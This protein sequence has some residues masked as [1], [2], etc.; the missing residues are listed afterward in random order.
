MLAEAILMH[1]FLT[2]RAHVPLDRLVDA[3]LADCA[4][5]VLLNVQ[6][7][8]LQLL[9]R[10]DQLQQFLFLIRFCFFDSLQKNDRLHLT[11]VLVDMAR[12][13][14]RWC[15]QFFFSSTGAAFSS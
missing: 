8:V 6:D 13:R 5:R 9:A 15:E 11:K 12:G 7:V 4:F 10:C 1:Y 3:L 14:R 2:D